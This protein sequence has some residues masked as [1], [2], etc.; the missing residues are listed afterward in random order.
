MKM[1]LRRDI[2]SLILAITVVLGL[3]IGLSGLALAQEAG[4]D[5]ATT[6]L[7]SIAE[8]QH[9]IIQLLIQKGDYA[10][11]IKEFQVI[12]SLDLPSRYEEA[13]FDETAIVTRKLYERG[14]REGAYS[15]LDMGLQS[16][17]GI[18]FRARLL[19]IKAGL[20]KKDGRINEALETYREEVELRKRS[21][22]R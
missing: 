11:A 12:L 13:V 16:V 9:E 15:V 6:R 20:L 18:E 19:N 8:T 7:L 22:S 14:Q 3:C 21:A 5:P 1:T 4:P 10:R 17:Q 2:K